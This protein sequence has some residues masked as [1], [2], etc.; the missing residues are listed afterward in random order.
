MAEYS[1]Y[2]I[3]PHAAQPGQI[4]G[5]CLS[6]QQE[7]EGW[8]KAQ[9]PAVGWETALSALS[10]APS[11]ASLD[12]LSA[13]QYDKTTRIARELVATLANFRHEG[14]FKPV[15]D[16]TLYDQANT[17]THLD[18]HWYR[19]TRA[20]EAH[21]DG[22]QYAIATGTAYFY[23]T[24]DK[25]FHSPYRGDIRLQALN[26]GDVTFIQLPKTHDIQRAYAVIIRE[27]M[28]LNLARAIY[29]ET[30]PA[31]ANQ[32][33]PDR[34]SPGWMQKGLQKLQQ[35]VSPALRVAGR[36]PGQSQNA[37]FPTVDIFH[38][39]TMDRSINQSGAPIRMGAKLTNWE[40]VVPAV[41]DPLPT[42][43]VNPATGSPFTVPATEAEARLF[44][45]RRY[46]IF[47]RTALCYDGPSPY[48]HGA[49]PI[50]RLT[51]GDW[52]WEALGSST[53]PQLKNI[54][55]GIV[56]LMRGIE[57]SGAA[58]LD[59]P[60]VVDD[61]MAATW[62]DAF[63]PRKAG[64]RARAPLD[65]IADPIKYPFPPEY[66]NVPPWI[67]EWITAQEARMD[68]L[69][70]VTDL[71][72]IAKAKQVPG[73]DTLEKLMEMAGPIVQDTIRRVENPLQ[74]LGEWRKAMYFQFYA[75][76]RMLTITGPEGVDVDKQ[77]IP[78]QLAPLVP[79]ETA[80]A[81]SRRKRGYLEDYA[82]HV[83]ESGINE[84]H[85]MTTKLL[86]LQIQKTGFPLSPWTIAQVLQ[87]P[88]FGPPPMGTNN[89]MERYI[90][91]LHMQN[92]IQLDL[93][94]QQAAGAMERGL[95]PNGAEGTGDG[96]P[97]EGG[98]KPPGE[99]EGRPPSFNAAPKLQNKSDGAG[100]QRSTITTSR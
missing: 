15:W 47:S 22:L 25:H 56:A 4:L 37:S 43:I 11:G 14:E 38:M 57:D 69:S 58:R 53:V 78:E 97:G 99:P 65:T 5:W 74:Q 88:N 28:P 16:N 83:T 81:M 50:A 32:L 35:F 1:S 86:Y 13:L 98:A 27:E 89:E 44:P 40:Y 30:N 95:V 59:P 33:T 55:D 82:Y 54:Q 24:W 84:I 34:D 52:A 66:Y 9:R 17:L 10:G 26:P 96:A 64:V 92:E 62:G 42:G 41:G 7:G 61:R 12:G 94:Q 20:N 51:F 71:V 70:G 68:Y 87:I 2:E 90:A 49:A 80:D 77:Y 73:A 63:N 36:S 29:G 45:L 76:P 18:E 23:Q 60:A 100:G 75:R 8:L 85:R 79:G 67:T 21:R 48:W 39:Y 19:T 3:P 31:F 93:A 46:T 72:A 91:W 6:A